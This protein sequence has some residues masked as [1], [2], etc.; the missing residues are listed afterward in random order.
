MS[1]VRS[2]KPNVCSVNRS[3]RPHV[4]AEIAGGHQHADLTPRF[5][6]VGIIYRLVSS[7]IADQH[8]RA[9]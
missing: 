1:D 6:D 8:V 2:D 3:I 5:T 7:G 4:V 9:H